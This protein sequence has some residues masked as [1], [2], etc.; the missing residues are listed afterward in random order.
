MDSSKNN[1]SLATCFIYSHSRGDATA[2][3]VPMEVRDM[4]HSRPYL[5]TGVTCLVV[6]GFLSADSAPSK[7]KDARDKESER[8]FDPDPAHPWNRL[9]RIFYVRSVAK[10]QRYTH[11]GLDAPFGS[12]GKVLLAEPLYTQAL[13]AL[14]AFLRAKDDERIKDPRKRA[15][16]QRDLWYIFDA[17]AEPSWDSPMDCETTWEKQAQRRTLEKRLV[18]VMRRLEQPAKQLRQLP[19]NYAL[20]S[21]SKAFPAAFDPK[22]PEQPYLPADLRFDGQGDWVPISR[23]LPHGALN[24]GAPFHVSF[25]QGRAVFVALI[26]L[27][28]GRKQT[29]AYLARMQEVQERDLKT[30]PPLPDGSQVALVRRMLLIDD[31]S[32]LQGTPVTESVQLRV[33]PKAAE[34]HFFEFTL[35]RSALLSGHGGLRAVGAAE[36]EF[37]G[38]ANAEGSIMNDAEPFDNGPRRKPVVVLSGCIRCHAAKSPEPFSILTFGFFEHAGYAGVFQTKLDAQTHLTATRKMRSYSWGLLQGLRETTP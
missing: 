5:T 20:T 38:F 19:D 24:L 17:L 30:F 31:R 34:Q 27:P 12:H 35:D 28:G 36:S 18:Q 7:D 4:N 14:D 16:L 22:R 15:L 33:F 2:L 23:F 21:Q 3:D 8:L 29:E 32:M 25:S 1:L 37:F 13:N 11:H 9:H 6:L 26:R 10:G